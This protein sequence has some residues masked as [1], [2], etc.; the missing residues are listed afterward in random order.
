MA[1]DG[2]HFAKKGTKSIASIIKKM[3]GD[4]IKYKENFLRIEFR[5]KSA[6]NQGTVVTSSF[7]PSRA[8]KKKGKG[9][10]RFNRFYMNARSL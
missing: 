9:S 7:K 4:K 1:G 5:G 3:K 10:D 2:V 6:H 8:S